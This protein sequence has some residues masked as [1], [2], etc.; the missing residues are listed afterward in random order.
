MALQIQTYRNGKQLPD[1]AGIIFSH[2]ADLFHIY[3]RTSGYEPILM[4]ASENQQPLAQ[5]LAVTR[6]KVHLLPPYIVKYC[7]IYDCGDFQ[8]CSYSKE[9]L[10]SQLLEHLTNEILPGAFYIKFRNLVSP[11]FGYKYFR[12]NQYFPMGGVRVYNSLHSKS[13]EE[14]LDSVR[15]NQIKKSIQRGVT[16]LPAET[17]EEKQ[18]FLHF[19]RSNYST[20]T[21]K[22]FPFH[23]FFESL[24]TYPFD[25]ES[26]KAFIVRY[27]GKIIGGS[28]CVFSDGRS[29]LLFVGGM[30]KTYPLLSPKAMAVWA[31]ITYAKEKGYEH[32]EFIDAGLPFDRFSYREFILSFGGKQTS[33]RQWYRFRWNWLNRLLCRIYV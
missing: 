28:L 8:A 21:R 3:E 15:K 33:T 30:Q 2:S 5:I 1:F 19:M 13:P 22:H 11:L 10:F 32:F 14:R 20:Q 23:R 12:Q 4:V 7:E 24:I 6:R 27:K 17:E 16:F 18:A 29:Y 26:A 9:E 31:A 25:K